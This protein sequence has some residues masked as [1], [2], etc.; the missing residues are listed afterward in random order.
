MG[1]DPYLQEQEIHY[2]E[3][4]VTAYDIVEAVVYLI[5]LVLLTYGASS[6]FGS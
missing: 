1:S 3:D 5:V 4:Q 2:E 6:V